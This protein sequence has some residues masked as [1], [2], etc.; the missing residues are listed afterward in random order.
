MKHDPITSGKRKA[1]NVSIDTGVVA[2]A[3]EVGL[4]LSQVCEAAIRQ[5]TKAE[6]DR[7]WQ[8][9]N[10]AWAEACNK[11]VEENGLPLERYR[12]F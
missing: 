4:N 8:E 12:M 5:A 3:R 10:R 1:V 11:W 7:R 9:E 6:Q 2:A